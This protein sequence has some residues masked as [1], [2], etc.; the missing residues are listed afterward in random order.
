M[1]IAAN[2]GAQTLDTPRA[3]G[4]AAYGAVITDLRVFGG[5]PAG[6]SGLK[7]W[8]L[9]TSTYSMVGLKNAGFVFQGFSLGK[10]LAEP[11]V[12]GIAYTPGSS[13]RFSQVQSLYMSGATP[14]SR[15]ENLEYDQPLA[16]GFAYT[17]GEHLSFGAGAR[18]LREKIRTTEYELVIRDTIAYAVA[19]QSAHN[20]S[21]W[22]LDASLLWRPI[23][24]L[25]VSVQLRNL[26]SLFWSRLPEAFAELSLPRKT[27][28]EIHA[29]YAIVPQVTVAAAAATDGYGMAGYELRLPYGIEFRNGAYLKGGSGKPLQAFS[30]GV[31]WSFDFVSLDATYL[32]FVDGGMRGGEVLSERFSAADLKRV[33]LN[34]YTADRVSLSIRAMFGKVREG[35][36]RI[37]SVEIFG[38]IYPSAAQALAYRP[39]GKAR[40]TNVASRPIQAR[41]GFMLE[42]YMDE[43][44]ETA[45]VFL[46]PGETLEIPFSA[47]F[48]SRLAG[49]TAMEVSDGQVFVTAT[50]AETY[51][52]RTT[53]RVLI[54]GRNAWNGDVQ[55]LRY[56]VTPDAPEVLR[57]GRDVLLQQRAALDSVVRELEP[58]VRARVL[59]ETFVGRLLYVS[60][61]KTSADYVQY[62][63]ETL[64]RRGGDCD[65]LTVLF[66]SLLGSIGISTAF[67]E[68]LP[69][70][71]PAKNHIYLL[72]DTGLAP[73]F[74]SAIS[75]NPKRYV[76]RRNR[77]DHETIWIP[78][79]TTKAPQGYDA[80]WSGGAQQYFDDVE[81]ELGL[82]KG[83]V[84]I[85]DVN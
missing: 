14:G 25:A 36:A 43:A 52:D 49:V 81:M 35:L 6:L 77:E 10:R 67:V 30:L 50:P 12:A 71:E 74:G 54:H 78:F 2:V 27:L 76:V 45:P 69:P 4:L 19:S 63:A 70:G 34:P 8:E 60:D 47:V 20:G 38:G 17:S 55:A 46:R 65:D 24:P 15:D 58:F 7:D 13:L 80:G 82:A 16:A 59:I 84:R 51:D 62:P 5:N 83:W 66:S 61:P 41:V 79:E 73:K 40:V 53:A 22:Q 32:R 31:G 3:I 11:L 72:F 56:F 68:V 28:G 21:S 23:Q 26:A 29:S 1:G 48:N 44:T 33:D 39:V 57:Y 85:V 64:E 37:E 42:R 75:S 9:L 18:L